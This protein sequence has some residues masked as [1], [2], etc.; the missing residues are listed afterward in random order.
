MS[1][2]DRVRQIESADAI[3]EVLGAEAD[4]RRKV[5]ACR[6]DIAAALAA[7]QERARA[8]EQRTRERLSR[9]HAHCERQIEARTSSL[10][11]RAGSEAPPAQLDEDDR[12]R[13]RAA[14]ERLSARL[15][16]AVDG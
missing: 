6:E 2:E 11:A 13:L 9:L 5:A 7:E 3:R 16:G 8:I 4:I 14:A 10:R 1:G 15:T 12:D